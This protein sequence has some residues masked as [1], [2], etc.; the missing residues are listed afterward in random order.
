M[1][2]LATLLRY[3]YGMKSRGISV[4]RD[5]FLPALKSAADSV[6]P[7]WLE[8]NGYPDDIEGLQNR[9]LAAVDFESPDL[10]FMVLMTDEIR[11]KTLDEISKKTR[12]MNW[13]CDDQWRFDSYSQ[14]IAA[15]ITD[16]ATVDKYS[17]SKYIK[18]GFKAY[19]VQWGVAHYN[20]NL[21]KAPRQYRYGISFVGQRNMVRDWQIGFLRDAGFKV[22]C[23]GTGWPNGKVT[24]REMEE[25]FR[26]SKINLNLS[27]SEPVD[28]RYHKYLK[29]RLMNRICSIQWNL[30]DYLRHIR[31]AW[32][33]LKKPSPKN[34]EQIK[35]RNFEIPGAGGFQLSHFAPGIE[36]YYIPGKEIVLCGGIDDLIRNIDYYL[37]HEKERLTIT[38]AG[39]LRTEQ[40]Q[41]SNIFRKLLTE[42]FSC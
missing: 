6:I 10:V 19:Q 33:A 40:Y 17:F 28:Y 1:K 35:A 13:F 8:D 5:F 21:E 34:A 38:K 24:F 22:E 36:D 42:L 26:L 18:L 14:D 25:I 12:V 41:Y 16:I 32:R 15:H 20:L 3:D 30:I 23:F 7:F 2:I 9:I 37:A 31:R 11:M 29:S 27:N 39:Y 4:E